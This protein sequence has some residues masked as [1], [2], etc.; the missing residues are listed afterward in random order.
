[1]D[2]RFDPYMGES[3]GVLWTI[4]RDPL[5]RTTIVVLALLDRH[6]DWDRL[7][8]KIDRGSR[9]IPRMRQRVAEY[10]LRLAAP[11]W[12][13]DPHFELDY[14]VRRVQAVPPGDLE[15]VLEQARVWAMAGFDR[16]RPLWEVTLVEGLRDGRAALVQKYHHSLSDGV[17]GMRLVSLLYDTE[18]EPTDE[19]PLPAAPAPESP[20]GL[21]L[22]REAVVRNAGR[23]VGLAR[24]GLGSPLRGA[25]RLAI[26]PG[27]EVRALSRLARSVGHV[28]AP[29]TR[30]LSPVMQDRSKS[31]HYHLLELPLEALRDAGHRVEGSL[32]DAF[33]AGIT[34]GLRRYHEEH[35]APVRSLRVTMPINLR[36]EGDALGGNRFIPARFELPVDVVDP[37]QRMRRLGQICRDWRQEPALPLT[38]TLAAVFNRLPAWF[39]TGF[40]GAMLKHVDFVASDVPG[41]PVPIYTAGARVERFFAL[42]PLS[43]AALNVTLISY[44]NMA[45]IGIT[46]DTGAVPDHERLAACFRAGFAEVVGGG[47]EVHLGTLDGPAESRAPSVP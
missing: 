14:H 33:L 9:L 35:G 3:D 36:E 10:P 8:A 45:C 42:G 24:R 38:E 26:N 41:I 7:R 4:E 16:T 12:V 43:G 31:W 5:L 37:D 19:G 27:R 29:A 47:D 25:G 34:G 17:G 18:R 1:M 30:T 2:E 39:T 44:R 32:N 13:V 40:F 20:G 6:P 11:R 23:A 15:S 46:S 22:A 28:L 21:D